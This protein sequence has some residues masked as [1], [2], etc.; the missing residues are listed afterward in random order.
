MDYAALFGGRDAGVP[1]VPLGGA[2]R[3]RTVLVTGAGGSIGAE[4][5]RQALEHGAAR[6]LLVERSE[7]ALFALTRALVRRFGATRVR[8][9]LADAGDR[10]RL[11]GLLHRE[12]PML[13]V[14][15]AAHK[16]VPL[17]EEHAAEAARNNVVVTR[18]VAAVAAAAKVERF[19]LVSTDKAV[20]PTSVMGASKRVA[21]LIVQDA[22]ARSETV[23]CAVRFGN[24]LG[25]AGSVIPLFREQIAEGG[26]VT[27]THPEMRRYFMSIPEAAQL[28]LRAGTIAEGGEILVLD[29][30]EPVRIL[31]LAEKMIRLAGFEP[32]VEIPIEIVGPRRGE[33]LVEELSYDSERLRPTRHP[34]ILAGR[35]EPMAHEVLMGGLAELERL[36]RAADD[37]GIRRFLNDFLPEA[38]LEIRARTASA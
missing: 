2:L 12:R 38:R 29:M 7:A 33:K 23:F 27:V 37:D 32:Y 16:H 30:G 3:Q 5:S 17:L 24:V 36:A 20:N 31:E 4:L 18:E 15:A 35:I 6:V 9:V 1:V 8:P 14:H 21:E 28:V 25:S 19:V 34:K 26:P 10:S 22:D 11:E 13:L